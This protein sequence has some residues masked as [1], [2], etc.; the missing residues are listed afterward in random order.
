MLLSGLLTRTDALGL[1]LLFDVACSLQFLREVL[2]QVRT[3]KLLA[4]KAPQMLLNPQHLT[5]E[6][7]SQRLLLLPQPQPLPKPCMHVSAERAEELLLTAVG[8]M[9]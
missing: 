4:C 8:E 6:V 1:K 9:Q 3:A 5:D 7:S 2:L